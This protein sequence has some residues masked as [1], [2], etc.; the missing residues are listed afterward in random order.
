MTVKGSAT[1]ADQT[2]GNPMQDP[3]R[4][5]THTP[6][7][8]L[9]ALAATLAAGA[10]LA[11]LLVASRS[12]DLITRQLWLDEVLTLWLVGDP[13]L[14]HFFAALRAGTDTNPPAMHLLMRLF[15]MPFGGADETVL[16]LFALLTVTLALGG[17]YV[18]L[19]R[20]FGR[21]VSAVAA[22][23]LLA[24]PLMIEHAVEARFYGLWLAALTWFA[25]ALQAHHAKPSWLRGGA[26]ALLSVLLC[27]THYFGVIAM[28][29]VWLGHLALAGGTLRSRVAALLP[30]LAGVVALLACVPLYLGQGAGMTVSSWMD[31]SVLPHLRWNLRYTYVT[32]SLG[33]P[34]IAWGLSVVVSRMRQG[35]S[36][37]RTPPP[38]GP[39]G[40]ALACVAFAAFPVVFTLL[41][42]PAYLARY[43]MPVLLGLAVVA[44][45]LLHRSHRCLL[46]VVAV[47]ALG[48][49]A[50]QLRA[51]SAKHHQADYRF[52]RLAEHVGKQ[53]NDAGEPLPVLFF[54]RHESYRFVAAFDDLAGR[55]ML[56]TFDDAADADKRVMDRYERDLARKVHP[57]Y[58]QPEL[59]TAEQLRELQA[60]LVFADEQRLAEFEA[61]IPNASIEKVDGHLSRVTVTASGRDSKP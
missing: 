18:L 5:T 40:G 49:G 56:L 34:L 2:P 52:N 41:L 11:A 48:V 47:A 38:L 3:Q 9:E 27:T 29:F 50:M 55:A 4:T 59:V 19:R 35:K 43:M 12:T 6:A 46:P 37:V 53:H 58:V 21:A 45:W 23:V 8:V 42:Q 54:R 17:G 61:S 25:V 30:S 10:L 44:A 1:D 15:A 57:Y 24:H 20:S 7:G 39:V 51:L 22:I 26:V 13:S 28:G 14:S 16:R 60:F 33:I 31:S 32:W 36:D